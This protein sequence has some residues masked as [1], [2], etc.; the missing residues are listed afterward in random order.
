[1]RNFFIIFCICL[2]FWAMPLLGQSSG[3]SGMGAA[4]L[5]DVEV[6]Q[7]CDSVNGY[8]KRPYFV[9]VVTRNGSI[10][11]Q[12]SYLAD[13]VT[14]Y[15][16]VGTTVV[17]NCQSPDVEYEAFVMCDNEIPF[18]RVVTIVLAAPVLVR[19]YEID[20][21]TPHVLQGTPTIGQCNDWVYSAL[22]LYSVVTSGVGSTPVDYESM[23][24]LNEGTVNATVNGVLL[25]PGGWKC[26]HGY[27][28][29]VL[30]KHYKV[31]SITYDAT[32]TVLTIHGSN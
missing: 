9:L 7:K 27:D 18:I 11:S 6:V 2:L 23:C 30:R 16:P 24:F 13:L 3:G 15:V 20:G 29:P 19:D 14:P 25:S 31:P 10:I 12:T 17:G 28:N 4:N 21:I 5:Y 32:G 26:W 22:T 8:D 1:M